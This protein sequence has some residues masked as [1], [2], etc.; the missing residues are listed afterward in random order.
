MFEIS[1]ARKALIEKKAELSSRSAN[2]RGSRRE[3][4]VAESRQRNRSNTLQ[5]QLSAQKYKIEDLNSRI[6]KLEKRYLEGVDQ[7]EKTIAD[8]PSS[9]GKRLRR[10]LKSREA[11]ETTKVYKDLAKAIESVKKSQY[12]MIDAEVESIA[13]DIALRIMK[14]PDGMLPYDY[15]LGGSGGKTFQDKSLLKGPM[16]NR[17]FEIPD[18]EIEEF[19]DNDIEQLAGVYLRQ[20]VADVELVRRFGADNDGNIDKTLNLEAQR[21]EIQ[22]EYGRLI[23]QAKTSK[24]RNKLTKEMNRRDKDVRAMVER[25]RG[26]YEL[27]DQDNMIHRFMNAS[28]NLNFLRLMGGVTISSFPDMARVVMSEGL[29]RT[30]GTLMRPLTRGVANTRMASADVKFLGIGT[31]VLTGGRLEVISDIGDHALGN[32]KVERGLQSASN[33][34]G[35]INLMNQWTSM[36]KTTHAISMQARVMDTLLKG[37]VPRGLSRLGIS[38]D[39]A[40]G[41]M[42]QVQKYGQKDGNAW[43]FNAKNWDNPDLALK[44]GAALKKESDRVIVVPGQEKPLFMSS[45]AGKTLFQF[46]SFM[47]SATQRI[48]MAALQRQ[49]EHLISGALTMVTFGAL[50]YAIKEWEAGREIS[51]DPKVWIMEGI[52]RSG[53]LGIFMEAN[54]TLEKV[55]ANN[56]GLRA[57]VGI[58][59]PASRFASRNAKE[60][61][62]GPTWGSSLSTTLQVFN[63]MSDDGEWKESDTRAVRRFIPGQNLTGFKTGLDKIE[64]E[65]NDF[66]GVTK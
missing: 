46:K 61:F 12:D 56:M 15:K 10:V 23:D 26:I 32:T 7:L 13:L 18:K 30:F 38:R 50:T 20:T 52:D 11:V 28:R 35:N 34:F 2:M 21:K 31:D 53:A 16:K 62:F 39:E 64:N 9:I 14:S 47:L 25:M 44:W 60:S 3:L 55:S 65:V 37:R 1:D 4:G 66:L 19:L 36:M 5:D 6:A 33:A 59:S 49:D 57:V 42:E 41:I 51:D 45:E 27:P 17:R 58:D 40:F 24:E 54:N 48:T 22:D 29:G 63:A 8:M 43:I